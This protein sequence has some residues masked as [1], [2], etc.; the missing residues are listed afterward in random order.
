MDVAVT[1]TLVTHVILTEQNVINLLRTIGLGEL[2]PMKI[3]C[4]CQDDGAKNVRK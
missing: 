4:N 2:D 3:A 1:T